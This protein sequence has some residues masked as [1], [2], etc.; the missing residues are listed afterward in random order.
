MARHPPRRPSA[1]NSLGTS[2]QVRRP[3]F[4]TIYFR[5]LEEGD[6]AALMSGEVRISRRF[7]PVAITLLDREE[8]PLTADELAALA[9]LPEEWV[10]LSA[11]AAADRREIAGLAARGVLLTRPT[12][13]ESAAAAVSD[14]RVSDD[15]VSDDRVSD[16]R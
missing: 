12:S 6:L 5:S 11:V 9:R 15:R 16:D 3:S 10:E 8:H 4:L 14:D 1:R 7:D 13:P 2:M